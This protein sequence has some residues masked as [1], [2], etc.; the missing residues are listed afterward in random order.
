MNEVAW[1]RRRDAPVDTYGK[2]MPYPTLRLALRNGLLGTGLPLIF[3]CGLCIIT[4]VLCETLFG[5]MILAM[6]SPFLAGYLYGFGHA[7]SDVARLMK[8]SRR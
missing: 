6:C 2:R 1:Y 4:F 8:A 5:V 7:V 3:L